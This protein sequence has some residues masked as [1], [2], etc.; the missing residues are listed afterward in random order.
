MDSEELDGAETELTSLLRKCEAVL[1]GSTL[2]A[3]RTTLM[4][5]RVAALRI[6]V[7]LVRREKSGSAAPT[8]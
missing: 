2:S 1:Q 7:E 4:T 8:T 6:A 5:N 3:S